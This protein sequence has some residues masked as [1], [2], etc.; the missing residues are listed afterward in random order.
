MNVSLNPYQALHPCWR[1]RL[2]VVRAALSLP[3]LYEDSTHRL[4]R[5][6]TEDGP[7]VLKVCG[8]RGEPVQAFWQG[9]KI[10]FDVDLPA[11]I[12]S[13]DRLHTALAGW[14]GLAIPEVVAAGSAE[15]G[16]PGFL[17]TRELPGRMVQQSDAG[18][19]CALGH[20]LGRLHSR[21]HEHWGPLLAETNRAEDWPRHLAKTLASLAE[22]RGISRSAVDEVLLQAKRCRVSEFVPVM[23]DLRWDQ[24]LEDG[25]RLSALVDLDAFV[26]GPRELDLVV[27]EYLLDPSQQKPFRQAYASHRALP[28]LAAVRQPYRLL[29]YLLNVLGESDLGSWMQAPRR[30]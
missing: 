24:F 21:G 22:Q 23:P 29:L 20:H 25:G 30:F 1:S 12:G 8:I 26:R 27:L 4:W 14:T 11:Q 3:A 19:A 5:L 9:M 10:L 17:L 6:A 2:P 28:D 15:D 16:Y 18:M 7:L 13:H